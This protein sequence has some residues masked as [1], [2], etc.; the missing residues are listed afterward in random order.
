M[1]KVVQ[2]QKKTF[3]LQVND[4]LLLVIGAAIEREAYCIG[5]GRKNQLRRSKRDQRDKEYPVPEL[6]NFTR[7]FSSFEPSGDF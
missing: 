2:Y 6:R 4:Q 3:L 1:V 5:D 7:G